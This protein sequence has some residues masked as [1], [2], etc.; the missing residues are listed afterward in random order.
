MLFLLHVFL[1]FICRVKFG[2]DIII[3][4]IAM[5]Y[6]MTYDRHLNISSIYSDIMK[7]YRRSYKK[8]KLICTKNLKILNNYI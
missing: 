7:N 1:R 4:T 6:Y 2:P 8:I 5:N 3:I